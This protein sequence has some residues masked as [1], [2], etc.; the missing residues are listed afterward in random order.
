MK[1]IT[2]CWANV[3]S[4]DANQ[5]DANYGG[6]ILDSAECDV[7]GAGDKGAR[8]FIGKKE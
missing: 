5:L 6:H 2:G 3:A 8:V 1:A 7:I 4:A